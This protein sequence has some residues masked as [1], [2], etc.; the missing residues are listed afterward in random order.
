MADQLKVGDRVFICRKKCPFP[1]PKYVARTKGIV[2]R[3]T[4]YTIVVLWDEGYPD[5]Q[6]YSVRL[7]SEYLIKD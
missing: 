7:A 3:I 2:D 1:L 4:V 6:H 5:L